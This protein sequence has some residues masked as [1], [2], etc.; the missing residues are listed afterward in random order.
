MSGERWLRK[1]HDPILRPGA[2][3]SG[4]SMGEDLYICTALPHFAP[5]GT[6]RPF[7]AENDQNYVFIPP[8]TQMIL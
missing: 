4:Q 5:E 2:K 8:G 1:V 3:V 7:H 6:L